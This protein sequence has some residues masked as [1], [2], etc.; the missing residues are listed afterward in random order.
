MKIDITS[1]N[2]DYKQIAKDVESW[3]DT[4][5]KTSWMR[6][7]KRV[8]KKSFTPKQKRQLT[9]SYK[10][11]YGWEKK[12]KGT[13]VDSGSGILQGSFVR[14]RPRSNR[15]KEALIDQ[16]NLPKNMKAFP[17]QSPKG[18]KI[19]IKLDKN[20]KLITIDSQGIKKSYTPFDYYELVK[21]PPNEVNRIADQ[22]PN[23]QRFAIQ[24]GIHN[25][26]ANIGAQPKKEVIKTINTW[27]EQ[28]GEK[29][30]EKWLF[31]LIAVDFGTLKKS[32][33]LSIE[34]QKEKQSPKKK[35][36]RR[37]KN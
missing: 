3:V 7:G 27:F 37:L 9:N 11:L 8:Y 28:Y 36:N 29:Q 10:T 19:H 5:F 2:K 12:T 1:K 35:T 18:R 16:L 25:T 23:K 24:T 22:Y 14:H 26:I 20:N 13:V 6:A 33:Q 32:K 4:D 31:G 15:V 30:P 21:N 34:L 17:I